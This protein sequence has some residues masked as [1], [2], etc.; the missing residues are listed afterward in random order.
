MAKVIVDEGWAK[1]DELDALLD[2]LREWGELPDA[3]AA[4]LYCG[5][6]GWVD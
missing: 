4:S 3:F 5:A 6:L 2:A 1:P